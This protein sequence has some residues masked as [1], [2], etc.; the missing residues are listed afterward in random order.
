MAPP[1]ASPVAASSSPAATYYYI[2]EASASGIKATINITLQINQLEVFNPIT[3]FSLSK[4][5]VVSYVGF[6]KNPIS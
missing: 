1:P 4:D 2:Q 3:Q 5:S 6:N